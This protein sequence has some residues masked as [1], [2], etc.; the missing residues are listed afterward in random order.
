MSESGVSLP[1]KYIDLTREERKMSRWAVKQKLIKM[2]ESLALA[3]VT[4]SDAEDNDSGL[5]KS[6]DGIYLADMRNL[7]KVD[8]DARRNGLSFDLVDFKKKYEN[9]F[10]R[11]ESADREYST[12][13]FIKVIGV[14]VGGRFGRN[15]TDKKQI[16]KFYAYHPNG[17]FVGTNCSREIQP[18]TAHQSAITEPAP[19]VYELPVEVLNSHH[20]ILYK[21]DIPETPVPVAVAVADTESVSSDIGGKKLR[22]AKKTSKRRS[23]KSKPRHYRRSVGGINRH[24]KK[25]ARRWQRM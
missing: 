2:V 6:G 20:V 12:I 23:V 17:E 16:F 3:R 4:L 10:F 7:D 13:V 1:Q 11:V 21:M 14:A 15:G 25:T 5:L 8:T 9:D 22:S 24:R 18:D 19:C